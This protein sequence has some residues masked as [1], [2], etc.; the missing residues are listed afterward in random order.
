M[1]ISKSNIPFQNIGYDYAV[2]IGP[3]RSKYFSIDN[4]FGNIKFN[5]SYKLLGTYLGN[6][7]YVFHDLGDAAWFDL[8]WG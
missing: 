3:G 7:I 6:R 8:T 1:F 5:K 4:W 2:I